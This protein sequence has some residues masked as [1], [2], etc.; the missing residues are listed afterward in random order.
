MWSK[1]LKRIGLLK[2]TYS[3][4]STALDVIDYRDGHFSYHDKLDLEDV[5]MLNVT[6][7][8]KIS[9]YFD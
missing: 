4:I 5:K 9:Y 2:K 6:K 7:Y 3:E 1:S 8:K